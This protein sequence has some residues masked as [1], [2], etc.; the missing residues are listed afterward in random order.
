MR[1]FISY[2]REDSK[3]IAGRIGDHL[4][5][6]FGEEAVYRDLDSIPLGADFDKHIGAALADCSV[7]LAVIGDRWLSQRLE[8]EQDYVRQEIKVALTLQAL[9]IPILVDGAKLP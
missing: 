9:V 6:A 5:A 8:D 4:R 2:R 3:G 1:I 7:F